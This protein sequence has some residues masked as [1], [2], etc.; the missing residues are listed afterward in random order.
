MSPG[1][2]PTQPA[3]ASVSSRSAATHE[4]RT[5]LGRAAAGQDWP[6]F[7]RLVDQTPQA[8]RTPL[9]DLLGLADLSRGRF[10]DAHRWLEAATQAALVSDP[11]FA[12]LRRLAGNLAAVAETDPDL[13][14]RIAAAP[15]TRWTLGDVP[16][17]GPMPVLDSGRPE[18]ARE[19][20][21]AA[22]AHRQQLDDAV[23]ESRAVTL[24][25]LGDGLLLAELA[26][27]PADRWTN[28]PHQAVYVGEADLSRIK[29]VL[30]AYDWS[31][32]HG[33]LRSPR[34][35][36]FFGPD[37]PRRMFNRLAEVPTLPPP[38][39]SVR[40]GDPA[41]AADYQKALDADRADHQALAER[42]QT[43]YRQT[44]TEELA[45]LFG[46]SPPRPPRVMVCV[47]RHTT[48]LQHSAR[49]VAAGFE[50]LG[51]Q[52][53]L[54]I[55]PGPI[56][57]L[58]APA[59]RRRIEAFRPDAVFMIDHL[60]HEM[61]DCFPPNLPVFSWIQDE[62]SHLT[63]SDAGRS[64]GPRDFVLTP[65]GAYYAE[66]FDYPARQCIY[67]HKATDIA[68]ETPPPHT[69]DPAV[70]DV[71]FVSHGSAD[72][73][74]LAQHLF[75]THGR[76]PG[77]QR[78]AN[79]LLNLYRQGE[80]VAT[81]HGVR[82]LCGQ[83][84]GVSPREVPEL[85]TLQLHNRLNNLLYRQQAV[86]WAAQAC[87]ELGLSLGLYGQGWQDRPDFA[88]YA[89]GPIAYG[90]PLQELTASARVNLQA[91]PFC[92]IHQRLLDGVAAGGFFLIRA[93]PQ[94][95]ADHALRQA[96]LD[97]A[98]PWAWSYA[99][100]Q[101]VLPDRVYQPIEHARRDLEAAIDRPL[102][103]QT[104]RV[105]PAW[106]RPPTADGTPPRYADVRFDSFEALKQR[107]ERFARDPRARGDVVA[108]QFSFVKERFAYRHILQRAVAAARV[109]LNEEQGAPPLARMQS[110]ALGLCA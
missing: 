74:Q 89:K 21:F 105:F 29:A 59:H 109:R 50:Q 8:Q 7:D 43:H 18:F 3:K 4:L 37:W 102:A 34:V 81:L 9:A 26:R 69:P 55:E 103:E 35:R 39:L 63:T 16:G 64:V 15:D 70:P 58:S 80:S 99:E 44:R 73:A 52:A 19:P 68:G 108:A 24:V 30:L 61:A 23:R 110:A 93:H 5:A 22:R 40:M 77:F 97:A 1:P 57:Q 76:D 107:L 51:W 100:L 83:A 31:A 94:D 20:L 82:T 13:A 46:P 96:L 65:A 36:L 11:T 90:R 98:C 106:F 92:C 60:R 101:R 38:S 42:I 75:D 86:A 10:D 14:H 28:Q 56:H 79:T 72:P 85:W 87:A 71:V 53:D 62:L 17:V 33:P 95:D 66:R 49:S 41:Q 91:L 84:L 54:F 47:S 88:R 32:P 104:P 2:D 48:V 27:I 78:C 25:G 45:A 6:A 67:A 12:A